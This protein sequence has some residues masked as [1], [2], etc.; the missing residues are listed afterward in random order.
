MLNIIYNTAVGVLFVGTD[1]ARCLVF[2]GKSGL[3]YLKYI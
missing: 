1:D 3:Q 2:P